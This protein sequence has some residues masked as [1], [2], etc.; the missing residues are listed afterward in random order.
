MGLGLPVAVTALFPEDRKPRTSAWSVVN[1]TVGGVLL[2]ALLFIFYS[3]YAPPWVLP[4][5][6]G[7]TA[8]L[9]L[10]RR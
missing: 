2:V 7:A 1:V 3:F 6:V 8:V 5:A 10:G 4:G 9:A